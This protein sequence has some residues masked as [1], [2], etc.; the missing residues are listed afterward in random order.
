MFVCCCCCCCF[1]LDVDHTW[2]TT[3]HE[4]GRE[5]ELCKNAEGVQRFL[6]FVQYSALRNIAFDL[7]YFSDVLT[8]R[9]IQWLTFLT[10]SW[11]DH[12][13]WQDV[14]SS[15][16]LT[17]VTSSWSDHV[18]WQDVQSRDSL[19]LMT[20]SPK[21]GRGS[22]IS[23]PCLESQHCDLFPLSYFLSCFSA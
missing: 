1:A 10:S 17:L 5:A 2:V 4:I 6:L 11:S 23:S 16:S 8:G 20:A 12:V 21:G 7:D 9:T 14:Q 15:D 22:L 13:R 18:R 3:G 19:T